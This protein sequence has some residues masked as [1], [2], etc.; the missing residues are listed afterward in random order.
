MLE[1]KPKMQYFEPGT[2]WP[3]QLGKVIG[4]ALAAFFILSVTV[5]ALSFVFR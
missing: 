1:G 4:D 2:G 3:E 5:L